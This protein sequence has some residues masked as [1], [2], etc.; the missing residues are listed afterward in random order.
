MNKQK[1]L[2]QATNSKALYKEKPYNSACYRKNATL[3][4]G[5][6]RQQYVLVIKLSFINHLKAPTPQNG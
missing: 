6:K 4:P 5:G 2:L 3:V 1:I